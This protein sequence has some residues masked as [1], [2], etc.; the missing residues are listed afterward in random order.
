M[1]KKKSAH[2]AGTDAGFDFI[3]FSFDVGSVDEG[4]RAVPDDVDKPGLLA[5]LTAKLARCHE[6]PMP[7][8]LF[9][10]LLF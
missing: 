7:M 1:A 3:G 10:D 8:E 6:K 2:P 5:R 9:V 4:L